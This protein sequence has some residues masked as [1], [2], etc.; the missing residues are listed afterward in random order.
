VAL[1]SPCA[2]NFQATPDLPEHD[3]RLKIYGSPFD[4]R[5]AEFVSIS[6]NL[7]AVSNRVNCSIWDLNG[8]KVASLAENL[9][10]ADRGVLYWDGK[11]SGGTYVAR[12][13]YLLLWESQSDAGSKVYR[14]Q[15]S[16]VI[17]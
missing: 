10:I 1:P 13:L 7:P 16:I 6:Y 17:K 9:Q 14:R 12:G 8:R 15:K 2:Q 11:K 3:E 4:V 5:K